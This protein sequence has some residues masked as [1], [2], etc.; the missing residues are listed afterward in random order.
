MIPVTASEKSNAGLVG[1]P[2]PYSAGETFDTADSA[3]LGKVIYAVLP[4][5]GPFVGKL[6]NFEIPEATAGHIALG[7]KKYTDGTDVTIGMGIL[8][9]GRFDKASFASTCANVICWIG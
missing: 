5:S 7:T 4:V 1:N 9:R 2:V 8:L 3:T 6:K